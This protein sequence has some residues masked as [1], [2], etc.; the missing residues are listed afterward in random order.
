MQIIRLKLSKKGLMLA[1]GLEPALRYVI[2]EMKIA[3]QDKF[4]NAGDMETLAE[5]LFDNYIM[6][7]GTDKTITL[8]DLPR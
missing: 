3:K 4:G 7:D 8:D 5:T 2:E 1:D 6:R